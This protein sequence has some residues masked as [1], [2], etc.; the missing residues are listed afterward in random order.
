ME[1]LKYTVI[2]SRRRSISIILSP[3]K[4]IT[5]RAP[6]RTSLR[7][8]DS[9]V[10]QKSGWIKKH[11]DK[12]QN[13]T[14]INFEKKY[15]DGEPHM[16]MGKEKILKITESASY[17]VNLNNGNIEVRLPEKDDREKIRFLLEKWYRQKAAEI[18][19]QKLEEIRYRFSQ[20]NFVPSGFVVR[21]LK[22]RWGSCSSKGKIT[23]NSGLV[24]LDGIF[25]DYV[26]I[27]ELCHLKHHNHSKEYYRLLT[28]LVP[29]YKTIRR[30]LR[31]Y[32]TK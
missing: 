17:E 24:K 11:L 7:T 4:G 28:E 18:F 16:F 12:Y 29:D 6:Y 15:A 9:F 2:L 21:P 1:E 10:K 5:I 22:S 3:D 30:E 19:V 26:I 23:I 32:I 31:K 25:A 20:Y 8:I 27:H 13:L 14:R